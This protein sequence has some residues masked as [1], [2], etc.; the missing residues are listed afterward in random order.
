M[1]LQWLHVTEVLVG[2]IGHEAERIAD[3]QVT[4]CCK[5]DARYR[6]I[7]GARPNIAETL[8]YPNKRLV[9]IVPSCLCCA[10]D[11][12]AYWSRTGL[13]STGIISVPA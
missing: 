7:N 12:F 2:F 13:L 11:G 3:S 5:L 8:R 6:G 10:H 4:L 1:Q 9:W